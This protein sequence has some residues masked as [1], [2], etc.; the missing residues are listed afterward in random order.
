M[1]SQ[2][3]P[4]PTLEGRLNC[5]VVMAEFAL[6]V[7]SINCMVSYHWYNR[8]G[9]TSKHGVEVSRYVPMYLPT[10]DWRYAPIL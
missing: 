8:Y 7:L 5:L 4:M 2:M 9:T 10:Y 1:G 6:S 3:N